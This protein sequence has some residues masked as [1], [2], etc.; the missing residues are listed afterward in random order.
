MKQKLVLTLS[1][2]I[3]TVVLLVYLLSAPDDASVSTIREVTEERAAVQPVTEPVTE[4]VAGR[5]D[6]T[7]LDHEWMEEDAAK[8]DVEL[9][10]PV[11]PAEQAAMDGVDEQAR[12]AERRQEEMASARPP[13]MD[14]ELGALIDSPTETAL[15]YLTTLVRHEAGDDVLGQAEG[16][17]AAR[18]AV[19]PYVGAKLLVEE[20][21]WTESLLDQVLAHDDIGVPLYV[22]QGLLEEGRVADANAL[23]GT[24]LDRVGSFG[25]WGDYIGTA[26]LPGTAVRGLVNMADQALSGE[27]RTELLDY[28]VENDGNDYAGRMRA[29]MEYRLTLPYEAYRERVYEELAREPTT[30]DPVWQEGVKRLALELEGPLPMVSGPITMAPDDIDMMEAHEYPA[31]LEDMTLRVEIAL[32]SEEAQFAEG[33]V[34]RLTDVV[35]KYS[36]WPLSES[37]KIALQRLQTALPYI[38]ESESLNA[39]ALGPPLD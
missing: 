5:L 13:Y 27:E 19:L 23:A 11:E 8:R 1:A 35:E 15:N 29:L 12:A 17:L 9:A 38:E 39:A 36:N 33:M 6:P 26:A 28:L 37:E 7:G 21:N 24:I 3:G 25:N 34:E 10:D 2:V 30:Y 14:A 31:M 16:F 18:D 4:P 22:W 32:R 20:A